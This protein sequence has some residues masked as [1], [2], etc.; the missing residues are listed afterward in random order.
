MLFAA[1]AVA[2]ATPQWFINGNLAGAKHEVVLGYGTLTMENKSLG[3]VRCQTLTLGS[4][5]NESEKGEGPTE[6]FATYGC[7]SEPLKCS[8]VFISDE[9]PVA[10][11]KETGVKPQA[12]RQA[13]PLPWPGKLTETEKQ[14]RLI[15][16]PLLTV[17]MPCLNLEVVFEGVLEPLFVN[18]IG[19]G[20][21]TSHLQFGS[22][23]RCRG[24]VLFTT[25]L[26]TEPEANIGYFTGE[27]AMIGANVELITAR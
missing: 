20:L 11:K 2:S 19:N 13:G 26:G 9:R 14:T 25:G 12:I 10:V 1:P 8:G 5:W 3:R 21:T 4:V 15:T 17:V 24:C 27:A 6:G 18:G 22:G 16:E 7:T 23:T